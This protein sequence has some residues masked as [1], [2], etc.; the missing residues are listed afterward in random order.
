MVHTIIQCTL[1]LG[2]AQKKKK[3]RDM[4]Y[5]FFFFPHILEVKC[6]LELKVCGEFI[7]SVSKSVFSLYCFNIVIYMGNYLQTLIFILVLCIL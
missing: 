2:L 5:F 6:L 4:K 1:A 7:L 3:K